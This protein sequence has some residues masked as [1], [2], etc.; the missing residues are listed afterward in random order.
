M[1]VTL[2]KIFSNVKDSNENF[3]F[4]FSLGDVQVD[5]QLYNRF[6]FFLFLFPFSL[7]YPHQIIKIIIIIIIRPYEVAL[8]SNAA[9]DNAH[10]L[11]ILNLE[12]CKQTIGVSHF[13]KF[14][15]SFF[16]FLFF[17]STNF[18]GGSK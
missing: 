7:I 14:E 15:V 13:P 18:F 5:N 17:F 4:S 16:F 3:S 9:R 12:K 8:C 10:P 11:M 2:E 6:D 1:L